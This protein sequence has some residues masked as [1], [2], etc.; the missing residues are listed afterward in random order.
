MDI[1]REMAHTSTTSIVYRAQRTISQAE[2]EALNEW[3]QDQEDSDFG[4][5][6]LHVADVA[7]ESERPRALCITFRV[8]AST[9]MVKHVV[10]LIATW[11]E[12][13]R[14]PQE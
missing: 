3:L 4:Q 1:N 11:I 5:M 10:G 12:E 14:T 8:P 2:L 6:A 7:L 13:N 9:G